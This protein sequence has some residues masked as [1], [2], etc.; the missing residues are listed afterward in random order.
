[1][2]IITDLYD[3]LNADAGVRAIVGQNTSPQ[4]SKIYHGHVPE[5]VTYPFIAFFIVSGNRIHTIP[6]VSDMEDQLIQINCI[7]KSAGQ[8]Q[9]L[10]DAVFNALEGDGFLSGLNGPFWDVETKTHMTT[11]DWHFLA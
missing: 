4:H 6:G 9:A 7:D 10:A 2:S 8:A 5:S 1:V 3:T 11:V